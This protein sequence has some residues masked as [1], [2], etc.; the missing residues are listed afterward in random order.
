MS[1]SS[2]RRARSR[3][4][5]PSPVFVGLARFDLRLPDS[6]SL[7]DKRSVLRRVTASVRQKFNASIA[8]VD[9]QDLRQR[10][11]LAVAVVT[12]TPFHAR[13]VLQEIE[14]RVMT[15]AGVELLGTSVD[16]LAPED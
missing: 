3:A 9:H 16:L 15:E 1:S 6:L 5:D 14:R 11:T 7:K 8:E 13:R 2:T 12:E 10:T 4:P